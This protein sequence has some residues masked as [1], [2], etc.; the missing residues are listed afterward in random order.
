M[1]PRLASS[2]AYRRI[3]HCGALI[4][5]TQY[6][7]PYNQPHNPHNNTPSIINSCVYWE[8]TKKTYPSD[9]LLCIPGRN[10]ESPYE[11]GIVETVIK[12]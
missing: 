1:L 4:N 9:D 5:T 3:V 2:N 7:Q 10:M 6:T 8:F 12:I 11:L